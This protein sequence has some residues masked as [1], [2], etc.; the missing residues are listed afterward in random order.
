MVLIIRSFTGDTL[1]VGDVGRPDLSSGNQTSEELAAIMYD[2]LQTKILPLEDHVILYPAHGAGSSCG[3]NL[4]TETTSTIGEQK[5]TNYALQQESKEAFVK[6]ITE[7]LAEPPLYFPINAKINKEGYESM[8][9]IL[10]SG[11]TPFQ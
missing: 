3:K 9:A 5:K 6:A 8:D 1:F 4:G 2:S 7:N 10:K 11:L